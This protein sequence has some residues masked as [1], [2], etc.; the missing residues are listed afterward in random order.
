VRCG[1][2]NP[3]AMAQYI[4]SSCALSVT[5]SQG[6][7]SQSAINYTIVPLFGLFNKKEGNAPPE[8]P[9]VSAPAAGALSIQQAQDLLRQIESARAKEL[10]A[11][12]VQVKESAV[13]SLRIIDKIAGDMEREKIKLE[14]LEQR[15]KSVVEN[16]RRTVV[17]SLRREVSSELPLPQS[18]N[19]ARK[20][21]ERFETMMKRFGEVSSSHGRML[22]SYMKKHAGRMKDEFDT[23]TKLLNETKAIMSGFDQKREPLVKCSGILNTASQKAS[24]IRSSEA[25]LQSAEKE[26][27]GIEG[28]LERLK[29]GLAVLKE[30]AEFGQAS[31][32]AQKVAE[33]E[34]QQEQLRSEVRDLFSHASR[35]FTKYS[36]GISRETEARLR[37]MSDEP[38]K[39]LYESDIL[40]Y[41][42]LLLEIRKSI[43]SGSI[44]LKDSDRMLQYLDA[45]VESLPELHGRAQRIK[46]E[47]DSL[48]QGDSSG[49]A[50]LLAEEMEEKAAQLAEELG[51]IRQV[52]EQQRRQIAV[53]SAEVDS[54]LKE[55]SGI[56]YEL[57]GQRYSIQY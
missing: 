56:L 17:A 41:S 54:L 16:S 19:D 26:A 47:I 29:G 42:S 43:G 46:E 36:Y 32:V 6:F 7:L 18:A 12:L 45:I 21:K 22:N 38:W 3:V 11:R 34:R 55:A 4:V 13:Q 49:S 5:R 33:A 9:A 57:T 44:Q 48:R 20:F 52:Q 23:L 8:V 1:A 39:V 30:S 31:A 25:Y 50:V 2:E 51:R 27:A 28:E 37:I 40:L 14:G 15:F 35:A 53:K 10:A 24:S